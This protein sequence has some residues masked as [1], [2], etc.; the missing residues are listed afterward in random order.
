MVLQS[1]SEN[2]TKPIVIVQR[3]DFG[4]CSKSLERLVIQFIDERQ[5]GIGHYDVGKLLDI[6]EAVR[7]SARELRS[8]II[9]RADQARFRQRPPEES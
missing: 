3:L 5:M 2:V 7:Q 4:D 1:L 9:R 8:Y 6:P